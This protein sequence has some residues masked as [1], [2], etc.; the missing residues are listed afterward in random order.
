MGVGPK[1]PAQGH[2]RA[3]SGSGM[4]WGR[5]GSGVAL[6]V[7]DRDVLDGAVA[8]NGAGDSGGLMPSVSSRRAHAGMTGENH[9]VGTHV[10]VHV[11][12]QQMQMG[13]SDTVGMGADGW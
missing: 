10:R 5:L 12:L 8:G 2:L 7:A 13:V 4:E 3:G 9:L 6:Q 1:S 11:G